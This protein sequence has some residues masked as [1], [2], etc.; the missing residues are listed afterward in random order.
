[1]RPSP[2]AFQLLLFPAA[3][4]A[5]APPPAEERACDK[6]SA[7]ACLAAGLRRL[8][9]GD[10]ARAVPLLQKACDG[11]QA[12]GCCALAR[13]FEA[14]DGVPANPKL[15]ESLR[16]QAESV[17]HDKAV[18]SSSGG[19]AAP[20]AAPSIAPLAPDPRAVKEASRL[21]AACEKQEQRA[22]LEL[23]RLYRTPLAG[24]RE[25]KLAVSLYD[26][27]CERG[28]AQACAE[29]AELY[30]AGVGGTDRMPRAQELHQKG[31][32]GGAVE[33]CVGLT[34]YA[35]NN[36]G[37]AAAEAEGKKALADA[38]D[39]KSIEACYF[40]CDGEDRA[41][42]EPRCVRAL[43]LAKEGCTRG[44]GTACRVLGDL[45]ADGRPG[46]PRNVIAARTSLRR[47]LEVFEKECKA[48]DAKACRSAYWASANGPA[49]DKARAVSLLQRVCQLGDTH[50]CGQLAS[51]QRADKHE[52]SQWE[53]LR[54]K[55]AIEDCEAD[56]PAA[57]A[58]SVAEGQDPK[59]QG[60]RMQ[61]GCDLGNGLSC[62]LLATRRSGATR[63]RLFERGCSLEDGASC[64]LLGDEY[65]NGSNGLGRDL[66]RAKELYEKG[67]KIGRESPC[68]RLSSLPAK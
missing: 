53:A 60:L 41:A 33:G 5:A 54:V 15:A 10:K 22:C 66:V 37:D 51:E 57:C 2:I 39:A 64:L 55:W 6:G 8:G 65:R 50:S 38:C 1:M 12:Q 25:I 16:Q 17:A 3:L 58:W 20:A 48:G 36:A 32:R 47:A 14:G 18:C 43:A 30:L 28:V 7:S 4:A 46:V 49:E 23:A 45:Q 63:I 40:L 42:I 67:C 29:L 52:Q 9:G 35:R 26:Q 11:G 27:A 31:C 59:P 21:E 24:K 62:M 34:N 68:S 19:A 13:Q 56:L 61:H 44:G